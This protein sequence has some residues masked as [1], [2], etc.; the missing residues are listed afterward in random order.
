M[1]QQYTIIHYIE[2]GKDIF[3]D[4]LDNLKDMQGRNAIRRTVDRVERG[5][6]GDNHFCRDG[7][8][9]LRINVGA[10][11]RVYYSISG[12]EIILLLC[13]GSK[14]T[15]Q[16]DINKAVEYLQKVKEAKKWK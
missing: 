16:N 6:L 7:V 10:G 1:T 9:E 3:Q 15:Q 11:Y 4:W 14:R 5:N 13:G 2:N 12:K 8:W